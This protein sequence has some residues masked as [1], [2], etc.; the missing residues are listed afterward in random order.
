MGHVHL[1]LDNVKEVDR[2]EIRSMFVFDSSTH[3]AFK[4]RWNVARWNVNTG[5]MN[6]EFPSFSLQQ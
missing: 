2:F 4:A 3:S 6:D 1:T 5:H